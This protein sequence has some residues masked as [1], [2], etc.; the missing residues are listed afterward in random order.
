LQPAGQN[1]NAVLITHESE[2]ITY[3]YERNPADPR[4]SHAM[5]LEVDDFGNVLQNASVVYPR[6]TNPLPA[7]EQMQLHVTCTENG[8]TNS[9]QQN[10]DHRVP[11]TYYTR[12]YELTGLAMPVDYFT[13]DELRSACNDAAVI[14]HQ[15]TPDGSLQKRLLGHTRTQY[16][17]NNGTAVL[18]FGTMESKGLVHRSFK[19][20]FNDA[21]LTTLFNTK[22]SLPALTAL[23][24]DAAKGG[25]IQADDY[26]W[27]PSGT[28]NYDIA[29][30]YLPTLYTDVFGNTNQVQYD[31]RFLFA[32]QVTN[33]FNNSTGVEKFNYRVMQ[34]YMLRDV[35]DNLTAVRFDEL[36]M[37]VS[38]FNIGKKGIDAGDEFDDTKTEAQGAVDF[39][40]AAMQYSVSEWYDQTQSPGFDIDDYKPRPNYAITALRDTH[41]HGDP[42]HQT[43]WQETYVYSNGGGNI[44]L[45]KKQAAPGPALQVNE[46]GTVTSIPD[47]TPNLRW[48]GNGRTII[49]NKGTAVKKYE[50]Y[51]SVAPTF[52]DEKDMVQLGVTS[53]I[54]YDPLN[55][56]VRTDQPNKTFTKVEF[57][58]WRQT[59]FDANDT[60]QESQWYIDHG[61]PN[62]L[63]PEPADSGE[64]AA[65]LAAKHY[66]TPMVN[67]LDS[68]G[69]AFLNSNTDG[70]VAVET[71][72]VQD[73]QGNLL[74]VIDG[75]GRVVMDYRY[76]LQG[77]LT[78]T[79]MDGGSRWH[80]S[81]AAGKPLLDYDDRGHTFTTDY[82][83]LQRPVAMYVEEN[84]I[85]TMF[86]RTEYGESL[87]VANAKAN[88]LLSK[89]Y[90]QYDQAGVMTSLQFDFKGNL[91]G[92]NLQLATN[93]Q[94]TVDWSDIGS[95]AL[96]TDIFEG[97]S[98]FDGLN[99]VMQAIAP[100]D[101]STPVSIMRPSYNQTGLLN[102][103][104]VTIRGAASA[105]TFV[106]NINYNAKGQREEIFYGNGTKTTYTYDTNT[107]SLIRLLTS[108]NNGADI[109][110]DLQYT[111]DPSGNIT[112][113]RDD[114]QADVFFDGE[115][116]RALNNYEYD[117]LYRLVKAG[118]RKHAGQTDVNHSSAD[119]RNHPFVNSGAI[120]P[121]DGQAF[122]NYTEQYEY[123]PT[124]NMLM[125]QHIAKNSNWT[126]TFE[127]D[128]GANSN[129]RLT[130]TA[131]GAEIFN[132]SYDV[133][134]NM[135][136]LET[137]ISEVWDFLDQFREADLGGGG[138]AYYVYN[139]GGQRARKVIERL[140]GSKKERIYL[141]SVEL[142]REYN[143]A[144][145][146]VLERES[147]HVTDDKKRIAMID[148]PVIRP[149]GN[150]ETQL[151]RYQ[152]DN[153][154][155]S[156][157][158]E[159]DDGAQLISYEE[160][161]PF[162]TTSYST[163]DTGR[164]VPAKRYRYTGKERDEESGL[165]YHGSRYYALWLCRWTKCD[166]TGIK[167]GPNFYSYVSNNPVMMND[168]SGNDGESCGA[169][170]EEAQA[171]YA[172]ACPI[173][174]TMDET[175]APP[176]PAPLPPGVRHVPR[177][178][179][180]PPPDPPPLTS[181]PEASSEPNLSA[182]FALALDL[183]RYM[184]GWSVR[185]T[186]V[187][188]N[189]LNGT[190]YLWSGDANKN[191][192]RLAIA[193]EGSGWLMSE[194][195]QHVAA[196]RNFAD[197]L[198]TEAARVFPGQSF[199]DQELFAMAGNRLSLPRDQMRGIWDPPSEDV[200]VRA[201]LGGH[202]VERNILSPPG[203]D[204][205]QAR[206]EIPAVRRTGLAVGG[207]TMLSG[208]LNIY[209]GTQ[210]TDPFLSALGIGGGSVEVAGGLTFAAGAWR[211]SAP[212]M[213]LGGR[214]SVVGT[215][216][217][218]PIV[219]S[220][221]ADDIQ[222]GDEY[223]QAR[224]T[225][226]A[227]GIVAPPAAFLSVYNEVVVQPLAESFYEIARRDIAQMLGISPIYVY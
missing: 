123:D 121:N 191:A 185:P 153:H 137:V 130:A 80:L 36:G 221:A 57:T 70:A 27:L 2:G 145:N 144:G 118:G 22:I 67:H 66:N 98:L 142:Y 219:I 40:G 160:Y 225:L 84:G 129:N 195:P 179:P 1:K 55:R 157:S 105:T 127:Y 213:R 128:N 146:I 34:P 52:D 203:P 91:T 50:P 176:P 7:A 61:S 193:N 136:G 88:N 210:E 43:G 65:W 108:R 107:F 96:E 101:A 94:S 171:C 216:I 190:Y 227:V 212:L 194:T 207:A 38:M 47:T 78:Q 192:A 79:S 201:V 45:K 44:I 163:V 87:P 33:A 172:E 5:V 106:T 86:Q 115:L 226:S 13:L 202:P 215:V 54:H 167:A 169:W 180:T 196:A 82:D 25:Y 149:V 11:G 41:Y 46:D 99:R 131:V 223:R 12:S 222:S 111:F 186:D 187:H 217:T 224:G 188:G 162:G 110:Q 35:N 147:L 120:S 85:T 175:P 166:P 158:I 198:R 209:G 77:K 97:S 19:A 109:L 125:Q 143:S 26:F 103:V 95:V 206:I 64:R 189:P 133:H 140:D 62:P 3:H 100:H 15:V 119:V 48:I 89:S 4:V 21:I 168:P 24:T 178:A 23:L 164:E 199:T 183:T 16:R 135:Y 17:G 161:F 53:I 220:H 58:P 71:R 159:L 73:I 139:A 141:G 182:Q 205:V 126:R 75:L 102:N 122:R 93:Y 31:T 83:V 72:N 59:S 9:V 18:P 32:E 56:V 20:A 200:A 170:D 37:V 208:G 90:K 124:G 60:V 28:T 49:N 165:N 151:V 42:L 92:N 10:L 76:G 204:T 81:N 154:L 173:E 184:V 113:I 29:N 156:A 174:S 214:V 132:Y 117:A 181:E 104:A 152:Y 177:R 155:N 51:F 138:T 6:R 148:T 14:D 114:A 112:T 134:G 30:F 150:M 74:Q 68:L 39:P 211:T 116:A 69:R 63:G 8:F 197:A 218:A